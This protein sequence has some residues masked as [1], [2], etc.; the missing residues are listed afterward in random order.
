MIPFLS[1]FFRPRVRLRVPAKFN[2]NS[3]KVTALMPPEQSG[4][5]LLHRMRERLGLETLENASLL[6][7]GC[8]VRFSQAILNT[9]FRI[10]AYLGVD[11]Y[12][13][14][15][16]FL[17]SAVRDRRMSYA[18]LDAYHPLFNK[19]GQPLSA[20]TRLPIAEKQYDIVSMFSVITHQDVD[21]STNI[22]RLLRRYV[23]DDGH[24]FFTCFLD[25]S[26]ATYEDR[27]PEKNGGFCFYNGTFLRELVE[28][29]GWHFVSHAPG[30]GPLIGDSFV[31]RPADP[32]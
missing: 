2:R 8:G 20:E 31:F 23:A 14:M 7:F 22:F 16:A 30:E 26:I 32:S 21:D 28:S 4:V 3:A 9:D 5:F 6:D 19:T 1:R 24:L 13:E 18:F 29:C 17:Q 27:S 12:G 11:N 10:G 15:I 25:E